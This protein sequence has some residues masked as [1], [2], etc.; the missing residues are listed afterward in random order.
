VCEVRGAAGAI[1]GDDLDVVLLGRGRTEV[2]DGD[3]GERDG[4]KQEAIHAA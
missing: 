4:E 1:Y 3:E 2:G